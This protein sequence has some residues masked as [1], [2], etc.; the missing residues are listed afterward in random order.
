MTSFA[1]TSRRISRSRRQ[2]RVRSRV[3]G[4]EVKPRL[5]VFRSHQHIYAQLIDD[6]AGKTIAAASD[7]VKADPLSKNS[8]VASKSKVK[9]KVV[10]KKSER[11]FKLGEEIARQA[12]AK[13]INSV[14]FDRGGYPYT[15]RVK[16]VA[17]GARK[18]GLVF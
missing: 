15:G 4:S 7:Q 8:S 11:A 17:E 12:L 14:V 13:K 16:A 9:A 2:V 5:S 1:P 18:G 10:G 3:T 6:T